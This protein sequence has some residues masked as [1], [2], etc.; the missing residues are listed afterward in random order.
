VLTQIGLGGT[1]S[2]GAA[3]ASTNGLF[4]SNHR[5]SSSSDRSGHTQAGGSAR[6]GGR[7]QAPLQAQSGNGGAF[8]VVRS[9]SRS[10]SRGYAP[11]S[12]GAHPSST[13]AYATMYSNP[14][15]AVYGYPTSGTGTAA[16]TG[17]SKHG[18]G[19]VLNRSGSDTVDEHSSSGPRRHSP[20]A[21][22]AYM[23]HRRPTS[24]AT[25]NRARAV[26][27][28][29][30]ASSEARARPQSAYRRPAVVEPPPSG[31]VDPV[32]VTR[33]LQEVVKAQ[34]ADDPVDLPGSGAL[35]VGERWGVR[36][37]GG[38]AASPWAQA[39]DQQLGRSRSAGRFG[40]PISATNRVVPSSSNAADA[41]EVAAYQDEP[42][43]PGGAGFSG[44]AVRERNAAGDMGR[45]ISTGRLRPA[46]AV[47]A[48]STRA[49]EPTGA[50]AQ[51]PAATSSGWPA[52]PRA[53]AFGHYQAGGHAHPEEDPELEEESSR[54]L[55]APRRTEA[56]SSGAGS[57]SRGGYSGRGGMFDAGGE[58][59]DDDGDDD[60][61][62]LASAAVAHREYATKRTTSLGREASDSQAGA[63][64]EDSGS[65]LL[66]HG[67]TSSS[68]G[69]DPSVDDKEHAR[70]AQREKE[71]K[72]RQQLR[73][74]VASSD[75]DGKATTD[76][77]GFGKVLGQGSF[78]KVR[79][80]WHRLA[81]AKVA[82]K[83]YEKS[84][85]KDAA[86]WKRV[87]QEIRLMERLNHPFIVRLLETI[88]NSKRIHI[89]M[90]YAGGGNLCNYVKARR[91]L[92]ESEARKIFLQVLLAVEYMHSLGIIHRDIK[93][94]NVL[95][96]SARDMK[97]VD[98]GFSVACRDPT[99]RLKVFCGTPSYMA[100]EIVQR[101]EYLGRP[102]DIWSLGVL[103]YACL[104][105]CFPFV[106][107]TYPELYK[108]IAA[109]QVRFP[110][111]VSN[112]ARDLI[113]RMLH[114][115]PQKRI[116]L[117]RAR[118]HP[119]AAPLAST[120][121]RQV[122]MPLDRSLLIS[123]DP[124]ADLYEA[125][126]AK[127]QELGFP[128]HRVV[129]SVLSRTRTC[130]STTYYLVLYRYGRAQ[131]RDA[132]RRM[133]ENRAAR[134]ADKTRSSIGPEATASMS[135]AVEEASR[136]SSHG[137][138]SA[139]K[140]PP[141][142]LPSAEAPLSS[143]VVRVEPVDTSADVQDDSSALPRVSS[144]LSNTRTRASTA[145]LRPS[146]AHR[147][148]RGPVSATFEAAVAE[149][150]AANAPPSAEPERR[151]EPTAPSFL[152]RLAAT[153]ATAISSV[154][155]SVRHK[156]RV[157]TDVAGTAAFAG[158]DPQ[159]Q[160]ARPV[161]EHLPENVPAHSST[162]PQSHSTGYARSAHSQLSG[163]SERNSS[164]T[165]SLGA[166]SRGASMAGM[167]GGQVG[168]MQQ[169]NPT[170]GFQVR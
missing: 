43:V 170:V 7:A 59:G 54:R 151:A 148:A 44:A 165:V 137:L 100:P 145:S 5:P 103:L 106:A 111:H 52:D 25:V 146:S 97:L 61:G 162:S 67:H 131:L 164:G 120:V 55:A 29:E 76:F 28:T 14:Y 159:Q 105:G 20:K 167:G 95:F 1:A 119:W 71:W 37:T 157:T 34:R 82:I 127:A 128:R 121:L 68:H 135:T 163:L 89:V 73:D 134:Q 102:V 84:K 160:P 30:Q 140:E 11:A 64:P 39:A 168:G 118:R 31:G 92:P 85:I 58:D 150:A 53:K 81:G 66:A 153:R 144:P 40:R 166:A 115:D 3:P 49:A 122:A 93:L 149:A 18:H 94:E 70:Q 125:A 75:F 86:Q 79:L 114:P 23:D 56:G 116:P 24:A 136:H 108:R 99:K 90:E 60:T 147:R 74:Y 6:S 158:P 27:A 10:S 33:R 32:E 117:G 69:G 129:E 161:T 4:S 16:T 13:P 63:S 26:T 80:A 132:S 8:G 45:A 109:A 169:P 155:A 36:T 51:S 96:D 65:G 62:A 19:P 130:Y 78:G 138:A 98:F 133:L 123:D 21:A 57:L 141:A 48:V 139:R 42:P 101:K 91:R 22:A 50:H 112:A 156:A 72:Q 2:N 124:A 88:E 104:C 47:P 154:T 38:V 15:G 83:S 110:D 46:S 152:D 77:Y 126:L 41:A 107:K 87:Q 113:R 9:G 12:T 17:S 35:G 143:K 142:S